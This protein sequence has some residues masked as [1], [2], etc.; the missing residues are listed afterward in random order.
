MIA[1]KLDAWYI[2]HQEQRPFRFSPSNLGDC[3]RKQAWLL[4]GMEQLPLEAPTLR[5]FELGHQRGERLEDVC[6]RIW[7]D[8]QSQVHISI[9]CGK[10]KLEGT[11]D[12]WIPSLKTIIDFKTQSVFGFGLLEAEGVSREY[13]LQIHAYRHGIFEGLAAFDGVDVGYSPLMDRPQ[14]IKCLVIYEAKDSDA[15][16]GVKAQSLKE[17]EVPWSEDLDKEYHLAMFRIEG[18]LIRKEQGNLD[19]RVIPE[20]PLEKNGK[21]SWKCRYCPIGEE[22]GECY[23]KAPS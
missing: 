13:Q 22:R 12:L 7:P 8:A 16:K 19:P 1:D 6:K 9:K 3:K 17:I 20:L 11:C 4:S 15:R 21:H 23:K 2:E 14:D 18:L 5:T 10:Y